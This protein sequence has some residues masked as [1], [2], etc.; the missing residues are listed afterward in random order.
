MDAEEVIYGF[1]AFMLLFVVPAI[2][3]ALLWVFLQ[4]VTFWQR[5][6]WFIVSAII[7]AL[8][9]RIIVREVIA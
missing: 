5:L 6:A 7:Y 4:P 3:A 9:M 1:L 2:P 8:L